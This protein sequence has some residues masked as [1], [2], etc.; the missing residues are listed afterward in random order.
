VKTAYEMN[1]SELG[2]GDLLLAAEPLFDVFITTDQNLSHQ[3][4]LSGRRLAIISLSTTSWPRIQKH[5]HL[6]VD[7]V[8]SISP[9]EFRSVGI[10]PE[11]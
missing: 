8:N 2:N 6:V 7:A 11:P 4:N 1:W 9:G 3:Q 10:P 5:V